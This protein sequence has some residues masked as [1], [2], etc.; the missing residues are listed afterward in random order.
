MG[1]N[2]FAMRALLF[3]AAIFFLASCDSTSCVALHTERVHSP[4]GNRY[5]DLFTG[6]CP[7]AAPQVLIAFERGGGGAGVFAVDDTVSA[8]R[9]QWLSD[10]SLELTI[11][12]GARVTKKESVARYKQGRVYISYVE[13]PYPSYR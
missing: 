8:F 11:P 12:V 3:P 4:S 6:P 2:L 5:A 10:D 7:G 13:L 1:D 9:A